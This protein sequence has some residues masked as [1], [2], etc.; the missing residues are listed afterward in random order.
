MVLYVYPA[1]YWLEILIFRVEDHVSSNVRPQDHDNYR[2]TSNL[3]FIPCR[4][5]VAYSSLP[6][7]VAIAG[8]QTRWQAGGKGLPTVDTSYTNARLG[9][10][11]MP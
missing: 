6:F 1:E 3:E 2:N 8:I 7:V 4:I 11:R 10:P 5:S 9:V